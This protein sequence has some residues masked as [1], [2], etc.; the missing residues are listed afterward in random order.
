MKIAHVADNHLGY[1]QYHLRERK[2]DFFRAFELVVDRV[3]EEGVE[4]LLHSGDLFESYHPDVETIS[5]AISQFQKLKRAGVKVVAI[6]GNHDRPLRKNVSPPQKILAELSLLELLD[7]FGEV[8]FKD[9][10]IAGFRY[11]PK[12]HLERFAEEKFYYFQEKAQKFPFSFLLMHQAVD[13]YLPHRDAY[14]LLISQLPQGFS[15]YAAGHIHLHRAERIENGSL[16]SYAGSTEFRT[17]DEI[18]GERG[19]YIYNLPEGEVE[20]VNLDGKLRPF[21][22][23]ET[24]EEKIAEE[25]PDFI[26][27]VKSQREPPIVVLSYE[28]SSL[29]VEK[30]L[31]HLQEIEKEALY[32]RVIK[33]RRASD[34]SGGNI[35]GGGGEGIGYT[36][37]FEAWCKES[38]L[39]K[40]AVELGKELISNSAE[41]AEEIVLD[42]LKKKFPLAY[43]EFK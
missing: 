2:L 7:P 39:S 6:T 26:E 4:L 10:Y 12:R 29:P 20:R 33:K 32:L 36:A 17:Y 30:F 31:E 14:E 15:H 27:K 40:I 35:G 5:F 19:F 34:T 38:G 42:F 37:L 28:F 3:I 41:S 16:F 23:L 1:T 9:I 18:K 8:E 43:E 11:L 13:Q 25:L 22:L 24:T 21:L